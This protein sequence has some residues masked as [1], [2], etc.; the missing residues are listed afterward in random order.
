M[1]RR[2]QVR[3]LKNVILCCGVSDAIQD[4]AIV[5]RQSTCSLLI[6]HPIR[7][8]DKFDSDGGRSLNIYLTTVCSHYLIKAP[9]SQ[10]V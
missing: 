7:L 8:P 10:W 3:L 9:C 1:H 4:N 6:E 5:V 2:D